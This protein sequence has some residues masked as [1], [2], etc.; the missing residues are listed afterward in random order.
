[1]IFLKHFSS[2]LGSY[3]LITEF[4]QELSGVDTQ[5][6][7]LLASV[8]ELCEVSV[9]VLLILGIPVLP[10][11]NTVAWMMADEMGSISILTLKNLLYIFKIS[12]Q[13]LEGAESYVRQPAPQIA[14]PRAQPESL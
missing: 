9:I 3:R 1:M 5:D 14:N 12:L 13:V 8:F 11:T 4:S 7:W 6:S 10:H 2:G